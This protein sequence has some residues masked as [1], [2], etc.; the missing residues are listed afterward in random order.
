M[1]HKNEDYPLFQDGKSDAKKAPKVYDFD[2]L[3]ALVGGFGRYSILLYAL[4]CVVTI[5]IGLQQLVQVFYGA[6]PEFTCSKLT[7]DA[8]NRTCDPGDCCPNFCSDYEFQSC[9][10][11]RTKRNA[12]SGCS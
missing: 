10:Q 11:D 5:P 4:M 3:L 2:D 8:G 1:K 6:T 9:R 12:A 7:A